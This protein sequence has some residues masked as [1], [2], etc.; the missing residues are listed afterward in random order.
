MEQTIRNHRLQLDGLAQGV[1]QTVDKVSIGGDQAKIKV[2]H[3]SHALLMSKAW[4]GKIL[5]L[6][7][8]NNHSYKN[9]GQRHSVNDI[10]KTADRQTNFAEVSASNPIEWIDYYRKEIKK[11]EDELWNWYKV[12]KNENGAV[13]D[14]YKYNTYSTHALQYLSEARMHLGFA[15]EAILENGVKCGVVDEG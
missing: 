15:L 8:D 3:A 9:D 5:S 12:R 13:I 10:E 14:P 7:P 11:Q 4:L 1:K 6:I 2:M